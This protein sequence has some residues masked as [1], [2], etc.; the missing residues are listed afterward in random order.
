MTTL[1]FLNGLL[2][3]LLADPA[4][5]VTAA[6]ALAAVTPTPDPATWQG[7]AYKVIELFAI[8]VLH[9]KDPGI[10]VTL[11]PAA[12]RPQIGGAAA[13][14]IALLLATLGM[15]ACASKP[16]TTQVFEIRAGYDAAV[17]APMAGYA[18]LPPCPPTGAPA[19]PSAT[20]APVCADQEV[21]DQLRKADTA[22][23]A[24]L[25]AA[26]T[27]VRQNPKMDASTAIAAAQNAV[28]A[29]QTIL[30][31]YNIK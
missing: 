9:A 29:A 6:A 26:E 25:D 8:N 20:S 22:A 18:Q 7:K 13:A 24:T 3:W 15:S 16:P 5:V 28:A 19:A 27:T 17:L 11:P 14:A 23:K 10:P 21:L 31:T 1:Q 12:A 2:D 4:H 30:A